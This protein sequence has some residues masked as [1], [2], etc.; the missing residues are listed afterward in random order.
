[1]FRCTGRWKYSCP[2]LHSRGTPLGVEQG[3]VL[4][5]AVGVL[6]LNR[7]RPRCLGWL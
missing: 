6:T 7:D 2:L 5:L 1:M 4:S 3:G